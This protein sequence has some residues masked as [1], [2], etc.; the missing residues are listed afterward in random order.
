MM[1]H[2]FMLA[3]AYLTTKFCWLFLVDDFN[4][5]TR[6]AGSGELSVAIEGPSK[7]KVSFEERSNG[8]TGVSYVVDKP[9]AQVSYKAAVNNGI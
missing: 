1:T 4:V 2:F 5:Y 7:G 6:E 9:G 3:F 8:M